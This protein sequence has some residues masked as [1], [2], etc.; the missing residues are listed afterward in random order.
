MFLLAKDLIGPQW[1]EQIRLLAERCEYYDTSTLYSCKNRCGVQE[2]DVS[3]GVIARYLPRCYCDQHC[4]DFGD[5]CF[6]FDTL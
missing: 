1:D 6:D 5:C 2:R 3:L 4:D